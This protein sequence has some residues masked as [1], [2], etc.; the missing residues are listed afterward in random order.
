MAGTSVVSL[1]P[2]ITPQPT[3][4]L[5]MKDKNVVVFCFVLFSAYHYPADE[6]KLTATMVTSVRGRAELSCTLLLLITV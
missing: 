3:L 2:T 6:G 4:I 1:S 5:L